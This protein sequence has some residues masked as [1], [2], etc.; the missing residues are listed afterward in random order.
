MSAILDTI[1]QA[2]EAHPDVHDWT[3]Q[4][5]RQTSTQLYLIG[6][7]PEA[8]RLARTVRYDAQIYRDH[9][10]GRGEASISLQP[11]DI[12]KLG[13]RLDEAVF[14]AGMSTNPPFTLPAPAAAYPEVES[15][16]EAIGTPEKATAVA[17]NLA[18]EVRTALHG[19]AQVHLSSM[20]LFLES[21]EVHLRTSTGVDATRR[22]TQVECELVITSRNARGEESE[23]Q[24]LWQRRR[25]ADLQ[26]GERARRQAQYARDSLDSRLPHTGDYLVVLPAE[27]MLPFFDAV[28]Y[29]SAASVKYRQGT[30]WEV[31]QPIVEAGPEA[32]AGGP[33]DRLDIDSDSTLPY[34][35]ETRAFDNQGLP[36]RRFPLIRD[37]RLERFWATQR[38]ADYMQ[39]P[40]TGRVANIVLAP[41]AHPAAELLTP[42]DERPIFYIVTFS[43]LNPDALTGEFSGEIRLGYQITRAGRVPIKGGAISGNVFTALTQAQFSTE[44]EQL[45]SYSGPQIC[46]FQ[47][48]TVTG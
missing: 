39:I 17:K 36:A 5:T 30:P 45:G 28:G 3:V 22:G 16:D 4:E 25:A 46:R 47:G 24:D 13:A 48:L 33:F 42:P 10:G 43:W 23:A 9:D 2:L 1:Q 35:L 11:G 26:V 41:G 40:A 6:N 44:T 34:G 14:L 32:A 38:Y 20:E 8:I 12:D 7:E 18:E 27:T 31:G 29:R 19:E 21:A 37:G 15:W